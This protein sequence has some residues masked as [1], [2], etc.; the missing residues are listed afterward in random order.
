MEKEEEE[1]VRKHGKNRRLTR[2]YLIFLLRSRK[3]S[4]RRGTRE[5][6]RKKKL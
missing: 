6:E 5:E 3:E 2:L 4:R 1:R